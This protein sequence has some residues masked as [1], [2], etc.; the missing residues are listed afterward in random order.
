MALVDSIGN[1]IA[2]ARAVPAPEQVAD[3]LI[4][5]LFR[6]DLNSAARLMARQAIAGALSKWRSQVVA[7]L[8]EKLEDAKR[9]SRDHMMRADELHLKVAMHEKGL[10]VKPVT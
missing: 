9:E 8:E 4:K 7:D 2:A 6:N 10:T 3:V 1:E 5:T